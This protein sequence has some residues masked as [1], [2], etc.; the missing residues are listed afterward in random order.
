MAF[1]GSRRGQGVCFSIV[2]C[3]STVERDQ[4]FI[5]GLGARRWR[6]G[7]R[8]IAWEKARFRRLSLG[9]DPPAPKQSAGRLTASS[10]YHAVPRTAGPRGQLDVQRRGMFSFPVAVYSVCAA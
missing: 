1:F 3:G 6:L 9:L 10:A 5:C 8:F 4:T 7:A 2:V